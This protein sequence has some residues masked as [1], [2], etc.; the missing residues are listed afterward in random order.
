MGIK[1]YHYKF[2]NSQKTMT[3]EC[4]SRDDARALVARLRSEDPDLYDVPV[5]DERVETPVSGATEKKID[6]IEYI[7]FSDTRGEGWMLKSR[8]EALTGK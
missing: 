5:I 4:G 8:Y 3:I 6:G 7:W 1:L 2:L